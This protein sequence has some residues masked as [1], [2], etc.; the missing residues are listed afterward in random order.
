MNKNCWEVKACGKCTTSLG[1]DACPVCKEVKLHEVHGGV[2][3][4]R[5]CWTVPHTKCG[6]ITQGDVGSKFYN[7]RKCDFYQMVMKELKGSFQLQHIVVSNLLLD[8]ILRTT[9]N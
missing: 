1:D 4:G 5:A 7:C 6:C 2:N 8:I 3:G 9:S